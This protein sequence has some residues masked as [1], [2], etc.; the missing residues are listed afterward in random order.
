MIIHTYGFGHKQQGM[1]VYG[2]NSRPSSHYLW[3]PT[4]LISDIGQSLLIWSDGV[5]LVLQ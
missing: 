1:K 2:L 5:C 3:N 4:L